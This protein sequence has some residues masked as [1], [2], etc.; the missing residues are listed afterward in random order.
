[1]DSP[2]TIL[3]RVDFLA[4]LSFS[5]TSAHETWAS[6]FS[7]TDDESECLV[8]V[9][10]REGWRVESERAFDTTAGLASRTL[11]RLKVMLVVV[12]SSVEVCMN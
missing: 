1:M 4:L 2:C 8:E 9:D 7:S 10:D 3:E 11:G 6:F 5:F 12:G